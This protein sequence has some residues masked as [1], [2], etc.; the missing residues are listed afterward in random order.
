MTSID[1]QIPASPLQWPGTSAR[2]SQYAQLS[3]LIR[4]AGL[5]DRR[6]GYY[7]WKIAVTLV[8]LAAGWTAFG[9][10]GNS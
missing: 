7:T 10:L 8:C 9:L 4:E 1:A 2:G 3:R 5:L 6:P